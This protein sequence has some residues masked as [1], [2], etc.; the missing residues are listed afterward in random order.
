MENRASS[1][2]FSDLN[3]LDGNCRESNRF[4]NHDCTGKMATFKCRSNKCQGLLSTQKQ[5]NGLVA[6]VFSKLEFS[7]VGLEN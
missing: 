3:G 4:R 5:Q 2:C 1:C 7:L 6:V